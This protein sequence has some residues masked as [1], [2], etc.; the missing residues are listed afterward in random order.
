[1]KNT[2]LFLLL[3]F[4]VGASAQVVFSV[5]TSR[6]TVEEFKKRLNE[7]RSNTYNPPT[8]DQLL[9]DW[10]R[11][12]IGVQEAE[13]MKLQSDPTV[14]ERFRQ[15]LYNALL[16][17]ELGK[18]IETL[19]ITESDLKAYYSHNPEVR[20][21]HIYIEYPAKA[22]EEQKAIALK[23][24]HEIL[25][26]V[27]KQLRNKRPFEDLVKLYSDDLS[28]KDSGGD[29]GFQSRVTLVPPSF[30]E[31][32]AKMRVGDVSGVIE[33]RQGYHIVKVTAKNSYED[34]DKR[35]IRAAVFDDKRSKLF[36][37]YF[38]KLKRQYHIQVNKEALRQVEK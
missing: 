31:T 4:S 25:E 10:I 28:T 13:K 20:L 26:D 12:E 24:A 6:I 18:K 34:A 7:Y 15:V 14:H 5:G 29:M 11:F 22:T 33:S 32:V 9:E 27:K 19:P 23:R 36:N 16:E 21:S 37:E 35:Q 30:Y 1:M 8:A 2:L 38:E 17:K 3:M